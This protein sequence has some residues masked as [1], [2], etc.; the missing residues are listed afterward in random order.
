[1]GAPSGPVRAGPGAG[2]KE[3]EMLSKEMLAGLNDQIGKEIGYPDRLRF[4]GDP[5]G[6][7]HHRK[8]FNEGSDHLIR[9]P[10]RPEDY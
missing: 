8:P 4:D 7:D 5:T 3:K 10:A 9:Q 2:A 1:M 6:R